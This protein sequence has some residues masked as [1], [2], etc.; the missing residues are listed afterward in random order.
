MNYKF[1]ADNIQYNLQELLKKIK[2]KNSKIKE[3]KDKV[4]SKEAFLSVWENNNLALKNEM[5]QL[6]SFTND[7]VA[8]IKIID[9]NS[10]ERLNEIANKNGF[11]NLK[12]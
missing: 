6:Q 9:V 4:A 3:L 1:Y 12:F 10:K 5:A 11:D 7:L 8:H 2:Q